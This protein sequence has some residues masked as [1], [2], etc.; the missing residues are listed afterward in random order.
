VIQELGHGPELF[1]ASRAARDNDAPSALGNRWR[2]IYEVGEVVSVKFGAKYSVQ[3]R[4]EHG[5]L[6]DWERKREGRLP[7][8]SS[9]GLF[10]VD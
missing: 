1:P 8:V 9:D 4:F 6:L 7:R 10:K 5:P 3:I 2:L